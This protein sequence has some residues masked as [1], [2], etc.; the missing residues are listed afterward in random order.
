MNKAPLAV[1]VA[2]LFV[3]DDVLSEINPGK[4]KPRH[5]LTLG[6]KPKYG[7]NFK[8]LDYVNPNAPKSGKARLYSI[9]S[10]DSFNSGG[11]TGC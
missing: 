11:C 1:L 10:F 4:L 9:G 2:C 5:A 3:G 7:P 8:H 6:D